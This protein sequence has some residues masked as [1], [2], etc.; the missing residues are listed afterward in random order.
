M[1]ES[2]D[3]PATPAATRV[4]IE[5]CTVCNSEPQ[6]LQLAGLIR[7]S[8]PEAEVECRT[9]RRGSFEVYINDTLVHS[10][11]NSLAFPDYA[12]VLER[13]R[14]AH[15]GLPVRQAAAQPITDCVVQ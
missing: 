9:G 11:L 2:D 6:C 14:D 1:T 7:A 12:D 10:K 13:V 4:D 8:V 5:Y 3:F 15:N